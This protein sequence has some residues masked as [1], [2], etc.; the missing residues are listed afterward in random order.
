[1]FHGFEETTLFQLKSQLKTQLNTK[2]PLVK[3]M[4]FIYGHSYEKMPGLMCVNTQNGG[5]DKVYKLKVM[6]SSNH[7]DP[8]PEES[9][10]VIFGRQ[11]AQIGDEL[12][13]SHDIERKQHSTRIAMS[14]AFV[15]LAA[16]GLFWFTKEKD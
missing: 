14:L 8:D 9:T 12:L 3:A 2:K 15:G 10:E 5:K 11:L 4:N 6:S 13:E 7:I 1:M 16:I